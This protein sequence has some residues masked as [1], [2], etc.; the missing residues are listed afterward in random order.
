[1]TQPP[2][3]LSPRDLVTWVQAT[4]VQGP[5]SAESAE[6]LADLMRRFAGYAED[7]CGLE[8]AAQVTGP[9]VAGFVRARAFDGS[10]PAVATMHLRRCAVRLLF[11]EGRRLGVVEHD[12]TF[13]LVLPT[14]T[15][16]RARPLTDEEVAL[17]RSYS[18]RT[19]SETRQP[20]AWALAEATAR[21]AELT[22]IRGTDVDLSSSRVWIPGSSKTEPRWGELSEWGMAQVARRLER[23]R[24]PG[25]AL[26]CPAAKVGVS[27]TSSASTAIAKTLKR[28]GLH[29]EDDVRPPS[30]ASWAG[31]KAFSAG[32][33]ID[34]VAKRLG[35]RSLDRAAAFI[36]FEWQAPESRDQSSPL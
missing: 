17:C 18:L 2:D 24:D 6:R 13:D 1:M 11:A 26:V 15:T 29:H 14:R 25:I 31:A 9:V 32:A 4:M 30:V 10:Q 34:E 23:M 36:G 8:W 16:L 5:F 21:S 35:I 3:R 12:P 27:A 28:A 22:R 20:A 19:M 33:S 7:G